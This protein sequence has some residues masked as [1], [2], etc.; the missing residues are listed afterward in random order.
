MDTNY[1]LVRKEITE[2]LRSWNFTEEQVGDLSIFH[3][4][5]ILMLLAGQFG[6][7]GQ[8]GPTIYALREILGEDQVFDKP[9]ELRAKQ[10]VDA[11]VNVPVVN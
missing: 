4:V 7:L 11:A 3:L 2:R 8:F 9:S 6:Y 10:T 5:N 1:N